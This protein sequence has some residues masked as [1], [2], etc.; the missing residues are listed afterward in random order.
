MS[1]AT[2]SK[3]GK[4]HLENMKPFHLPELFSIP[5]SRIITA[6]AWCLICS[7]HWSLKVIL[8]FVWGEFWKRAGWSLDMQ[9]GKVIHWL[10]DKGAAWSQ[11]VLLEIECGFDEDISALPVSTLGHPEGRD[12][13]W[14]LLY[15]SQMYF[16]LRQVPAPSFFPSR[17]FVC[18]YGWR[19]RAGFLFCFSSIFL[20]CSVIIYDLLNWQKVSDKFFFLLHRSPCFSSDGL[21]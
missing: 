12:L 3:H 10:W 5:Y 2:H 21:W 15:F 6:A 7:S 8:A 4:L 17:P 19:K 11:Q 14:Q 18:R 9:M 16:W 1:P 13:T 20:I